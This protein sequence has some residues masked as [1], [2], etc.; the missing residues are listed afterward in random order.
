MLK[1]DPDAMPG[2]GSTKTE[3]L[4]PDA[5]NPYAGLYAAAESRRDEKPHARDTPFRYSSANACARSLSYTLQGVEREPFDLAAYTN[6]R[7]GTHMHEAVQ[8]EQPDAEHEVPSDVD[9]LVSGSCDTIIGTEL[10]E[11]KSAADYSYKKAIGAM[12]P[13]EGPKTDH[14]VQVAL[15]VRGLL[16][17]GRDIKTARIVYFAKCPISANMAAKKGL[18]DE[19]RVSASWTFTAEELEPYAEREV[20]RLVEIKRLHEAGELAP[21]HIPYEMPPGARITDVGSSSW[22]LTDAEGEVIDTGSAWGGQKC[23]GYC[24]FFTHC[25]EVE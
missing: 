24:P 14:I 3:G 19:Q 17:E 18:T 25:Q 11:Y 2:K 4:T 21:R 16:A 6:F 8:D 10:V 7:L 12:G 20:K 1:R 9:G 22:Q 23:S 5:D 15:N 13:A